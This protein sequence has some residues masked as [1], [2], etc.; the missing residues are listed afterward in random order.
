ML[1][2]S[3]LLILLGP[4]VSLKNWAGRLLVHPT[5]FPFIHPIFHVSQLCKAIS[6]TLP[7]FPLPINLSV[8]GV[9]TVQ[10]AEIMGVFTAAEPIPHQRSDLLGRGHIGRSHVGAYKRISLQSLEFQLSP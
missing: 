3:W 9:F 1:K 4:L 2:L 7:V 6:H 8:D 10:L 5:D